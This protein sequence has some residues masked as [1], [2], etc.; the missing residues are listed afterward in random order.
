MT[1]DLPIPKLRSV[2]KMEI[3]ADKYLYFTQPG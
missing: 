3:A 1:L 2:T